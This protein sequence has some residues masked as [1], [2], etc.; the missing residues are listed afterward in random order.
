MELAC[1]PV[2]I[3]S[4]FKDGCHLVIPD[5]ADC[6]AEGR[7]LLDAIG[8]LKMEAAKAMGRLLLANQ[9]IP[10]PSPLPKVKRRG[11]IV[12]VLELEMPDTKWRSINTSVILNICTVLSN[13]HEAD[14]LQAAHAVLEGWEM[15]IHT[16]FQEL[17]LRG[18]VY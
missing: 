3:E 12:T 15:E 8:A 14:D 11:Y 10:E 9:P 5:F 1:Y 2:L 17:R 16:A 18:I 4:Q 7:H 6:E 13:A